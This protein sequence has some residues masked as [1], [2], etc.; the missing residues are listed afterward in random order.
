MASHIIICLYNVTNIVFIIFAIYHT[1][2]HPTFSIHTEHSY[3][4]HTVVIYTHSP[5]IYTHSLV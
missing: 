3:F 4:L 1:Y 5:V 2:I